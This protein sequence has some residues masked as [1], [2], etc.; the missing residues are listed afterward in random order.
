MIGSLLVLG[1]VLLSAVRDVYFGHTFQSVGFFTVILIGC[2]I[3]TAFFLVVSALRRGSGL[4]VLRRNIGIVVAVNVTTAIAWIFY[5]FALTHISP[6]VAN[7]LYS[8]IGPLAIIAL[9]AAGWRI[10]ARAP[11]R[12][13]EAVLFVGVGISLFLIAFGAVRGFSGVQGKSPHLSIAGVVLAAIAGVSLVVSIL[14]TRKL[15]DRGVGSD[16]ILATRFILIV[17][18]AA[19]AEAYNDRSLLGYP[20]TE[21][22]WLGLSASVLIV[23]PIYVLQLGIARSVPLTANIIRALGPVAVF[24]AQLVDPRVV[25]SSYM[26]CA[27]LFY[28]VCIIG[29]NLVRVRLT[30][31]TAKT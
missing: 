1:F 6:A 14:Y 8:G 20:P 13:M 17:V 15:H 10:V 4:G 24:G 19:V 30:L 22:A 5:F 23:M 26:L 28:A 25:F 31:E 2:T 27:L 11:V 29:A 7:T 18:I 16:A 3:C 21:L 9:E 12:R